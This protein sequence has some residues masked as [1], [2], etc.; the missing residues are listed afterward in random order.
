MIPKN[1][2]Y[3]DSVAYESGEVV[4]AAPG[5][6]HRISGFNAHVAAVWVQLHDAAAMPANDAV[7]AI[8]IHVAA[9]SAFDF[10][11]SELGRNCQNGISVC[12]SSK[13]PTKTLSGDTCWFS[14]QYT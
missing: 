5:V 1:V 4:K 9:T 2:R 13:G 10:D 8:I 3:Y 7:P 14:I 12:S 11:L 6:V